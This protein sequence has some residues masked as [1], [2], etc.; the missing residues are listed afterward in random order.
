MFST[1]SCLNLM[2]LVIKFQQKTF[3]LWN[4][5]QLT[6]QKDHFYSMAHFI[7]VSWKLYFSFKVLAKFCRLNSFLIKKI[8]FICAKVH[9]K[10][11]WVS[12]TW[13]WQKPNWFILTC[14]KSFF[15]SRNRWETRS[16]L[17]YCSDSGLPQHGWSIV[18]RWNACGYKWW[19]LS[20][21]STS[22]G[23][24]QPN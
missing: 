20:D 2:Y 6:S 3:H 10:L 7:L 23:N 13:V 14:I 16:Q 1:F 9:T 17:P 18:T 15:I 4:G 19:V 11:K 24:V 21:S 5:L 8:L 12:W 22:C